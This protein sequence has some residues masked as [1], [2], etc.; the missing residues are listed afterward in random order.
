[1]R[2]IEASDAKAHLPQLLDDVERGETLIITRHGRPIARIVPE[3]DRRQE[4][5][6]QAIANIRTLRERN[7]RVTVKELLSAREEGRKR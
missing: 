2:E 6:D 5:V 7:G 1:M 3:M 4:V